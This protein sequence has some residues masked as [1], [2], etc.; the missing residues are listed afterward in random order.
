MYGFLHGNAAANAS[1]AS[2]GSDKAE[3]KDVSEA[4]NEDSKDASSDSDKAESNDA[5]DDSKEDSK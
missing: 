4:S 2:G 3:S 5:S 1:E